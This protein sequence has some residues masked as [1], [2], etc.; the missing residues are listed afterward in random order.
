MTKHMQTQGSERSRSGTLNMRINPKL[1][2]LAEVLAKYQDRTLSN[3]IEA[4][5]TRALTDVDE[6]YGSHAQEAPL[7]MWGEGLWDDD[8]ATRFFMLAVSYPELLNAAQARLW[9]LLTGA[10]MKNHQK[11]TLKQFVAYY[12]SPSI[13]KKH[14]TAASTGGAE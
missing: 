12:N 9:T 10:M 6:D 1:K 13:D 2:Y 4:A 11:I 8:E 14:L 3:F 7:P 5:I